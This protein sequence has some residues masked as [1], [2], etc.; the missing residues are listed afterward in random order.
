MKGRIG[1]YKDKIVVWGD[2][3]LTAKNEINIDS[4]GGEGQAD[5]PVEYYKVVT[6]EELH[7]LI[8]ADIV[9]QFPCFHLLMKGTSS[10]SNSIQFT[11]A[12]YTNVSNIENL[13]IHAFAIRSFKVISRTVDTKGT[14]REVPSFN[15]IF[16]A[17]ESLDNAA[18]I[19]P[20]LKKALVPITAEEF[21]NLDDLS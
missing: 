18:E 10:T 21:Y 5:I 7:S 15:N 12:Q 2:P 6:S 4:L 19:L 8:I 11:G 16:D 13:S 9:L 14:I 3:N 1:K 20:L 17:V